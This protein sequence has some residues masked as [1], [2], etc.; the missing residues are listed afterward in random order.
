ME[1]PLFTFLDSSSSSEPAPG[2]LTKKRLLIQP[3]MSV[4]GWPT[5]A[6]SS[7]L[8]NFTALE[9][10]T[11]IGLLR[12]AGATIIGSAR[13]SE[14]GF[15]LLGD[16]LAQAVSEDYAEIG[17]MTDTLGETRVAASQ[18]GL[19][20]FKP[21]QAVVSRLGLIGLVPSMECFSILGKNLEDILAT[22]RSIA[23]ADN[24]DFSMTQEELPDFDRVRSLG[25]E[26]ARLAVVEEYMQELDH[27]EARAF[28]SALSRFEHAGFTLKIVHLKDYA[29]FSP[30][31][32]VVGS[33]EASSSAGKFD[34]VRYGHRTSS[35]KN[36]NEMYLKSRGESFNPLIKT[37]LFQGAYFQFE[38][39]AAF[40]NAC[41]IRRSLV[42]QTRDALANADCILSLTCR[43]AHQAYQAATITETYDA[44]GFTLPA[45]VTGQ[46]SLQ[47]PGLALADEEDLGVLLTGPRLSDPL[48]FA[49][50]LHLLQSNQGVLPK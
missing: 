46:P 44:F 29:L 6:G 49:I 21:S 4:C 7:A 1:S 47:I 3:N 13:M 5:S 38:H 26:T 24:R 31:H 34:G 25:A 22:I 50:A 45:N 14:L 32:N 11:A 48:L 19:W 2:P 37:Y 43:Q 33:V 28:E 39:Y 40:E 9:D 42:D 18:K 30:V 15:G 20:G 41:R 36:W 27:R 35:A 10:A 12:Q 23:K 8:E 17:L 16:T